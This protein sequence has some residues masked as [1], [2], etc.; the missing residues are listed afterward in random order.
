MTT[1]YFHKCPRPGCGGPVEAN[2]DP[3]Y[4]W[5]RCIYCG[6]RLDMPVTRKK[7]AA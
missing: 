5:L 3:L 4:H 1:I 6:W 7:V 2:S